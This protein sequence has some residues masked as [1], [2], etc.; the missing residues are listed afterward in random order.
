MS[1]QA[2][3]NGQNRGLNWPTRRQF[4]AL[5]ASALAAG[6]A[7]KVGAAVP[8][9]A[10]SRVNVP[11]EAGAATARFIHPDTGRHHG[12]VMW[13]DNPGAQAIARGLAEQGWSVLLV[14]QG[15]QPAQQLH[16]QAR[17][18]VA[19]LETQDAVATTGRAAA[20]A[21]SSL[22]H[23]YSLRTISGAHSRLSLASR[24]ERRAAAH[25]VILVAVADRHVRAG[26]NPSLN[27]AARM[28]MRARG[29]AAAA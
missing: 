29:Q 16:R 21:G 15:T 20:R 5:G 17:G 11:T 1:D 9:L 4:A 3:H 12:L 19:W 2:T 13:N 14:D 18:L 23:G 6:A 28:A 10:E 26:S 7:G 22:G 8:Q 25:S 24:D 27:Q